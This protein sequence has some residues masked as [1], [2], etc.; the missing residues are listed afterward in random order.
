MIVIVKRTRIMKLGKLIGDDLM[1]GVLI[2]IM[3]NLNMRRN[4][5]LK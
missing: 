5:M 1:I 2:M 3:L 4:L